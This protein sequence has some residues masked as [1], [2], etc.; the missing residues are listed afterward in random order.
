[1]RLKKTLLVLSL[2][3]LSFITYGQKQI[4]IDSLLVELEKS[5]NIDKYDILLEISSYY[6]ESNP[7]F[8]KALIYIDS[9][10]RLAEMLENEAFKAK[11]LNKKGIIYYKQSDY[12]QALLCFNS[13]VTNSDDSMFIAQCYSNIGSIYVNLGNYNTASDYYFKALEINETNNFKE[14]IA[15]VYLNIAN[16]FIQLAEY[17]AALDFQLKSL[18]YFI[19]NDYNTEIGYCLSNIG[20]VYLELKDIDTALYY[21]NRALE[22]NTQAQDQH[23]IIGSLINIGNAH[24]IKRN[25]DIALVNIEK[26]RLLCIKTKD[27][28]FLTKCLLT[29]VRIY[30][31]FG[32][33]QTAIKLGKEALIIAIEID[34]LSVAVNANLALSE[35]YESDGDL[36]NSLIYYKY[37]NELKDSIYTIDKTNAVQNLKIQYETEKKEQQIRILKE[38]KEFTEKITLYLLITSAA[39]LLT[40]LISIYTFFLKIRNSKHKLQISKT[41]SQKQELELAK[42]AL[43]NENLEKDLELKHKE[44]TTNAMN[45]IRNIEI[46][47]NLFQ[48]LNNL[49]PTADQ[50]QK[51]KIRDIIRSYKIISQDKGWKEFELRFGQVHKSFYQNLSKRFPD[52]SPNEKKLCAFLRLN[53]TTKDIA[54]LTYKSVNTINQAR[55]RLRKKMNLSPNENLITFLSE[56]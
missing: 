12:Q 6:N 41:E 13:A 9:A 37:Y 45:L 56:L 30:K 22:I 48:E 17:D 54:L 36:S 53:M 24:F 8:D 3:A 21:F 2:A 4:N 16:V 50:D 7:D 29:E 43:E 25:L 5:P 52:L 1:M 33:I 27:M 34:A 49:I 38:E 35:L 14:G 32:D 44:L 18:Q 31:E 55:K 10:I 39:L 47:A 20:L 26:A 51:E 42:K 23:G 11:C 15:D 19:E 28:Y 40:I 46:N